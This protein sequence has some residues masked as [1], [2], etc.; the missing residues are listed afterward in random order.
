MEVGGGVLGYEP[1]GPHAPSSTRRSILYLSAVSPSA[2][3]PGWHRSGHLLCRHTS[4]RDV[5]LEISLS[6]E[7]EEGEEED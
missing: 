5:Q 2:R 7:L 6:G 1:N 3:I 4:R